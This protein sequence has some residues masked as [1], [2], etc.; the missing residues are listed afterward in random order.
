MPRTWTDYVINNRYTRPLRIGAERRALAFKNVR[1][2]ANRLY[3]VA[4][5]VRKAAFYQR[6]AKIYRDYWGFFKAG[7]W[8]ISAPPFSLKMPLRNDWA[9]LDWDLALSAVGHEPEIKDFYVKLLDS[10]FKPD[11]FCDIGANYG[12]HS[13]LFLSAGISSIAFEP[14][15][16]CRTYFNILDS[17]NHF[18]QMTWHPVALGENPGKARLDFPAAEPW[19][20]RISLLNDSQRAANCTSL[21]VE[22]KRLDDMDIPLGKCFAK[23]DTEGSELGVIRGG[24]RFFRDRCDLFVFESNPGSDRTSLFSEIAA[25]GFLIEVLPISN[26]EESLPLSLSEF[27]CAFESNFLARSLHPACSA[28]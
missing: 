26:I 16:M 13:A 7:D 9:W 10:R 17:L 18:G 4:G 23:I 25:L 2:V 11:I 24:K 1:E 22:V 15:P 5:P 3:N 20:G 12:L 19:L 8:N 27:N 28:G 21:D 6:S 14:N